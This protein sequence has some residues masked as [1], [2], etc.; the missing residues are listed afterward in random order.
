MGDF[1]KGLSAAWQ[2]GEVKPT[3]QKPKACKR[4]SCTR[5]D[6]FEQDQTLIYQML[7]AYSSRGSEKITANKPSPCRSDTG[8]INSGEQGSENYQ[9]TGKEICEANSRSW[10]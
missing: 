10:W 6:R 2:A 7:E 4:K 3:H 9:F 5:V 1:L 8:A